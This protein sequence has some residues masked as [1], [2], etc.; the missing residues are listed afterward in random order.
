LPRLRALHVT[1]EFYPIVK[2]GG[3]A[4]VASGLTAA[5]RQVGIDA[6]VLVPG[7]PAVMAEVQA[8][9][10]VLRDPG[11]FHGGPARILDART[12]RG[13]P[14]FV[15]DCPGLFRRAGGPY[16]D[17]HGVDFRDNHL[18]FAALGWAGARLSSSDHP[19]LRADILHAHDWQAGL[20]VAYVKL[21]GVPGPRSVATIHSIEYPGAFD[22]GVFPE[23][24][25]PPAAYS[26]HGA[27]FYG[28]VSYL[29]ASLYYADRITTVSPTYA[30]EL[31]QDG[32][33][34]GFEGL[35]RTRSADLIG[36]LN[37]VD[38]GEWSPETDR[39]LPRHY[40]AHDFR[41]KR[42]A[43]QVLRQRLGLAETPR[44]PLFGIV[45]RLV[46]QKG[47]DWVVELIPWLV[48]SGAQLAVLG[49][50]DPRLMTAIA[51]E[52]ARFPSSVGAMVGY[53]EAL[54]HLVQGGSDA[55]LVPSRTEP[56]GLT[57]L[58]ALRYGSPPVVRRTGGLAD[59]VVDATDSALDSGIATGFSFDEPSA[60]GLR[61]ALARAIDAYRQPTVW[62]KIQR[63]GMSA[64]YGWARSA[65]AYASLYESLVK[66]PSP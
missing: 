33:G 6:R 20:A 64:D 12:K 23:I 46:W 39:H 38:Y 61:G 15:L 19:D 2:T 10:E 17:E 43:K 25:L 53:D 5:L 8:A 28:R 56:C 37:G 50:G 11:L 42:A 45:S 24:G 21:G 55:M 14:L 27:E 29:K 52:T 16:V 4:D 9:L 3:L 7:Y 54:S 59:S 32:R 22:A 35:L 41:G 57:Q 36:I 48:E 51:A 13:E 62:K 47:I 18:R 49:S 58:Y 34:G 44:T 65:E 26:V 31:Q 30:R 66:S 1:S 60:E 40:F 63:T